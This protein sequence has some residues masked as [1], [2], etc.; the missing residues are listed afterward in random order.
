IAK[1]EPFAAEMAD[2]LREQ[3]Q[4]LRAGAASDTQRAERAERAARKEQE[5]ADELERESKQIEQEGHDRAA[6]DDE[7][8]HTANQLENKA[9]E[10]ESAARSLR[11]VESKFGVD[12]AEKAKLIK[13]A[14]D[15][16]KRAEDIKPDFSRIETEALVE[17]GIPI[18]DI[19]GAE[20]MDPTTM[21]SAATGAPASDDLVAGSFGMPEPSADATTDAITAAEQAPLADVETDVVT[22]DVATPA[23]DAEPADATAT[24]T[25]PAATD[26]PLVD[27]GAVQDTEDFAEIPEPVADTTADDAAFEFQS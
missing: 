2:D 22:P 19:P 15:S 7:M 6:V 4:L 24:I 9:F 16:L 27:L 5:R 25:E 20:L 10:L 26:D 3:A 14:D 1:N 21:S 8:R 13:A 11:R 23:F 18:S 12:D 17:A